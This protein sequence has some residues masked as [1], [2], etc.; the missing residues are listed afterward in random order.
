MGFASHVAG[1]LFALGWWIFI[2]GAVWNQFIGQNQKMEGQFYVPGILGTISFIMTNM[3]N[4]S[5]LRGDSFADESTVTKAKVWFFTSLLI[6]MGS[7]MGGVWI[8]VA[9]FAPDK[10]EYAW[11]GVSILLQSIFL[12]VSSLVFWVGRGKK[13][14]Y[15]L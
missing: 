4:P 11:P 15:G 6:G 12:F 10:T 2:D 9:F 13:D 3:L 7:L 8:L 14:P 1:A 5:D